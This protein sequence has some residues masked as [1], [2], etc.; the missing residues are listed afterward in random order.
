MTDTDAVS[1]HKRNILFTNHDLFLKILILS[2]GKFKRHVY[3]KMSWGWF[4]NL[5]KSNRVNLRQ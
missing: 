5:K 1:L 2:S 4:S 3:G